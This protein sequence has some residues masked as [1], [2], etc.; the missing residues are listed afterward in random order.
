MAHVAR[1]NNKRRNWPQKR[2]QEDA[3]SVALEGLIW[4]NINS[5]I[6]QSHFVSKQLSVSPGREAY[7]KRLEEDKLQ[8]CNKLRGFDSNSITPIH[9]QNSDFYSSHM[10]RFQ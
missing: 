5:L 10:A 8:N 9:Q 1:E 7:A 3:V 6:I 4:A 2:Q